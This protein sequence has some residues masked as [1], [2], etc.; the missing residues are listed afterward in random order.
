MTGRLPKN[1]R[2]ASSR[3]GDFTRLSRI[4]SELLFLQEADFEALS[5][6]ERIGPLNGPVMV[7]QR[8]WSQFLDQ[9]EIERQGVGL[10]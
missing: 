9:I 1:T 3:V 10:T 6:A 4:I 5:E 7:G 2:P 8:P